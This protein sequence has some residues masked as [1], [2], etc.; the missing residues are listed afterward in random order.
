MPGRF[1]TSPDIIG[2]P[3][4]EVADYPKD[5]PI[6]VEG[7]R[8]VFRGKLKV[9]L[10]ENGIVKDFFDWQVFGNEYKDIQKLAQSTWKIKWVI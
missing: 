4:Q 1:K 2:R 8:K 9:Y 10:V 6:A 3:Y 7:N 5:P